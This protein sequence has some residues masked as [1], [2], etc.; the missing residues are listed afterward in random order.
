[1]VPVFLERDMS[2]SWSVSSLTFL[3]LPN[4]LALLALTVLRA[5]ANLLE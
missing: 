4:A 1:M 2:S 3:L 5:L